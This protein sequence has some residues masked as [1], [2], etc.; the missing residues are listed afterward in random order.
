M[1]DKALLAQELDL[2]RLQLD[3][4][5]F[6][7]VEDVRVSLD[8]VSSEMKGGLP[9][10][11]AAAFSVPDAG[12]LAYHSDSSQEKQLVWF[13]RD[14]RRLGTAGDPREYTQLFLSPD[15]KLAAVSIRNSK[16]DRTHWNLWLLHLDTNV[17]S[18][19]TFDEGLQT[20]F[21]RLTPAR[22]YTEPTRPRRARKSI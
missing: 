4:Q 2:S 22:S 5:P 21:G 20:L 16:M 7:V 9:R 18:P 19:L 15:E 17:L 8:N 10:V 14:G 12:V 1:R 13:G 3:G 11:P 6:S